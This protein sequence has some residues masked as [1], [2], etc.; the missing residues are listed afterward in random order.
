ME[1]PATHSEQSDG[2]TLQNRWSHFV[3]SFKTLF[4]QKQKSFKTRLF[5]LFVAFLKKC[6]PK[7][8]LHRLE[9][10]IKFHQGWIDSTDYNPLQKPTS[11][12]YLGLS[13]KPWYKPCEYDTL[14]L[15]ADK[16]EK[17]ASDIENEWLA[18]RSWGRNL[19]S[20]ASPSDRHPSLK[21]DDWGEFILWKEGKFT[22]AGLSLFPKT[23][24]VVSELE[25]FL[26]PFGQVVFFVLKP[27]VTLP[28]HHDAS[29][30]D[31]TCQLGLIIPE[32][33]GIRVG[34][35]TRN[36]IRGKVLFF[37]HSFEHEAWNKSQQ[38]RVV[39]LLDLCHP[40]LTKIE[41]SLLWMYARLFLGY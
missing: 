33:C 15:V 40:E 26:I 31:I 30:I 11:F 39:L 28:P 25:S 4:S 2:A 18:H 5:L 35:E 3:K 22:E 19:V 17:N 21:E 1:N 23:V 41:R 20:R 8:N 38:A 29:N 34:D 36:W 16:L 13:S 14:K 24:K 27:G 12:L 7:E 32:N 6:Y 37:D 10:S 9:E